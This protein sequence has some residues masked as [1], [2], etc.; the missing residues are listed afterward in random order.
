M[1]T[2]LIIAAAFAVVAAGVVRHSTAQIALVAVAVVLIGLAVTS[3]F[4]ALA[5]GTRLTTVPN[6]MTLLL[7]GV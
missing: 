5:E 1:G 7:A 3:A 4:I 2:W 6:K